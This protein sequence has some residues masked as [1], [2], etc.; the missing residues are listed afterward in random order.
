MHKVHHARLLVESAER[1][2]AY[3]THPVVMGKAHIATPAVKTTEERISELVYHREVGGYWTAP[4]RSGKTTAL[5]LIT[6]MIA[7]K[8][9]RAFV[10]VF[11]AKQHQAHS[12][13]AY[14]NDLLFDLGH[15]SVGGKAS[16]KRVHFLK[17]IIA[18]CRSKRSD[19]FV[20][21]VD[22]GQNWQAFELGLLKDLE[23]DLQRT[24]LITTL[25]IFFGHT[26]M[27]I[28]RS[29]L[30]GH[31]RGDLVDRYLVESNEF[32]GVSSVEDMAEVLAAYDDPR[33][34]QFPEGTEL[35]F[36][37]FLLPLAYNHGWRLAT[38]AD[39]A[40]AAFRQAAPFQVDQTRISTSMNI[41]ARSVRNFFF[42]VRDRESKETWGQGI[43]FDA[44]RPAQRRKDPSG[45]EQEQ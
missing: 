15:G 32:P 23:N 2:E 3:A 35:C 5:T 14:F 16:D 21:F 19:Y 42:I 45:A 37:E 12:E 26:N 8:F 33:L 25:T 1:E 18:K 27:E 13:L 7:R 36:S 34:H 6:E 10:A 40:W 39:G 9:P 28:E 41:V 24:A 20:M 30:L 38:E 11:G 43:W 29:K 44:I 17:T 4:P 31:S 22:E